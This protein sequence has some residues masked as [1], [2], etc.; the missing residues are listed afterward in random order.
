MIGSAEGFVLAA[1]L[2][3]LPDPVVARWKLRGPDREGGW[4]ATLRWAIHRQS[5]DVL[6]ACAHSTG[7]LVCPPRAGERWPID[8]LVA[9]VVGAVESSHGGHATA[10]PDDVLLAVLAG[11]ATEVVRVCT[12][13]T[14]SEG[15]A[16]SVGATLVLVARW[17]RQRAAESYPERPSVAPPEPGHGH[18]RPARTG[19]PPWLW[20]GDAVVRAAEQRLTD[21]EREELASWTALAGFYDALSRDPPAPGD[22]RKAV[23]AVTAHLLHWKITL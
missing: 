16:Q 8:G 18:G 12:G 1:K 15:E 10:T 20:D 19:A 4:D 9:R 21:R 6:S 3:G 7:A 11:A 17:E 2:A 22:K 5:M 14:S 13:S 23:Q